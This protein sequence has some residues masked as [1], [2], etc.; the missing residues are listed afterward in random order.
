MEIADNKR[1]P[2]AKTNAHWI[3]WVDDEIWGWVESL[4]DAKYFLANISENIKNRLT[5]ENWDITKTEEEEKVI[6]RCVNHGY[7]YNTREKHIIRYESVYKLVREV[8]SPVCR[9]PSI[10]NVIDTERSSNPI[11]RVPTPTAMPPLPPPP[12][13]RR[14]RGRYGPQ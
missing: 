13:R 11:T 10:E 6:L 8:S 12:R 3:L 2:I 14:R 4:D 9:I 5:K 7:L 1:M